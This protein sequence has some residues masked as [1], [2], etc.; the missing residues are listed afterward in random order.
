MLP[1]SAS[2]QALDSALLGNLRRRQL[3]HD[4]GQQ[5]VRSVSRSASHA[6]SQACP[7]AA[8][9]LLSARC[10]KCPSLLF[11]PRPGPSLL[12]Q[13]RGAV[14]CHLQAIPSPTN[15]QQPYPNRDPS[16]LLRARLN[17]RA[18]ASG[19]YQNQGPGFRAMT[20]CQGPG[21]R[22][23]PASQGPGFRAIPDHRAPPRT[24]ALLP[25]RPDEQPQH[26]GA[27]PTA[28]PPPQRAGEPRCGVLANCAACCITSSHKGPSW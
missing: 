23:I 17:V 7:S 11:Q 9:R 24:A 21:L 4:H 15:A 12:F 8:C 26:A 13:P 14:Q 27:L 2:V 28:L 18:R 1:Q 3:Q 25:P 6:S 16:P 20:A 19:Q 22:A 5:G 10:L